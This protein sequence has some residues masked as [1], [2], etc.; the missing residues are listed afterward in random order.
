MH[1]ER[2]RAYIF[3]SGG[4]HPEDKGT[5]GTYLGDKRHLGLL[6]VGKEL[7]GCEM[8]ELVGDPP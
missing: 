6:C 5:L 1:P 8:E 2:P 3:C 7:H 4:R